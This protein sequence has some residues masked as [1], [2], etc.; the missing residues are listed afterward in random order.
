MTKTIITKI[1]SINLI[2][3][4]DSGDILVKDN[5][6]LHLENRKQEL[7]T[8]DLS[9]KVSHDI[10][11]SKAPDIQ[12]KIYIALG[13]VKRPVN[14]ELTEFDVKIAERFTVLAKT[15]ASHGIR[16]ADS[17]DKSHE[18]MQILQ[19]KEMV[20]LAIESG[21][22]SK[23]TTLH[24]GVVSYSMAPDLI[25]HTMNHGLDRFIT[26]QLKSLIT[27][28][29]K[30]RIDILDSNYK[31]NT[32]MIIINVKECYI[33]EQ[34]TRAQD[35]N[36]DHINRIFFTTMNEKSIALNH[37]WFI[38]LLVHKFAK[39][40]IEHIHFLDEYY[41]LNNK[42]STGKSCNYLWSPLTQEHRNKC[43]EDIVKDSV[44]DSFNEES[45][46]SKTTRDDS[47][48]VREIDI[49]INLDSQK[50]RAV[51]DIKSN[52]V[53]VDSPDNK[54]GSNLYVSLRR[55]D[56]YQADYIALTPGNIL[57]GIA[58]GYDKFD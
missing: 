15:M 13:A 35:F 47:S 7:I 56:K 21:Q 5:R 39:E 23:D 42:I 27:A 45:D 58:T 10:Y 18:I 46:F 19:V 34:L 54:F 2:D 22:L 3:H 40:N 26:I 43:L 4:L 9:V 37:Q 20:D 38:N 44:K 12:D 11:H 52:F 1:K 32:D 50:S 57:A 30:E 36:L 48:P 41:R 16:G 55:A 14:I 33:T 29:T 8:S 49:L 28:I 51:R 6:K 53:S 24:L 25:L 17:F 31:N